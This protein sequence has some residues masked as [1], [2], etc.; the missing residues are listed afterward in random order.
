MSIESKFHIDT[1]VIFHENFQSEFNTRKLGGVPSGVNYENGIGNFNSIRNS[2][3][4]YDPIK[5]GAETNNNAKEGTTIRIKITFFEYQGYSKP[6]EVNNT[7][8]IG[9]YS[10]GIFGLI[11]S[12]HISYY[13]N[14]AYFTTP[15]EIELGKEYELV[16]TYIQI[17]YTR[18]HKM[19]VNGIDCG[20]PSSVAAWSPQYFYAIGGKYINYNY[21]YSID[22]VTIWRRTLSAKEVYLL[23]SKKLYLPP[24]IDFKG[25][26]NFY[27]DAKAY[28][29]LGNHSEYKIQNWEF[30]CYYKTKISSIQDLLGVYSG[31]NPYQGFI[32]RIQNATQIIF[33]TYNNDTGN[34]SIN[35]TGVNLFELTKIS[36]KIFNLKK[37]L[38][39]ND[40]LLQESPTGAIITYP[41]INW[42]MAAL[43]YDDSNTN[44]LNGNIFIPKF[45][46]LNSSGNRIKELISFDFKQTSGTT[47]PNIAIDAPVS[48]DG[49]V[50]PN[51]QTTDIWWQKLGKIKRVFSM[52]TIRDGFIRDLEGNTITN[53][54][55][56]LK[57]INGYKI[58]Y[59]NGTELTCPKF[60]DNFYNSTISLWFL[61][62]ANT[63]LNARI[64]YQTTNFR[65]YIAKGDRYQLKYY[66]NYRSTDNNSL[67][68]SKFHHLLITITNDT[69]PIFDYYINGEYDAA[70]SSLNIDYTV[71]NDLFHIGYSSFI[72]YIPILE[73]FD[74]IPLDPEE[75]ATQ[76]YNY[77]KT[78]LKII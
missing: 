67:I 60:K 63:P 8:S 29:D 61:I 5:T 52:N 45:Y 53:N 3:I 24:K 34:G 54:G 12:T 58:P 38:W 30:E 40:K 50:I 32:C 39:I 25:I 6:I 48:S 7:S 37:Q 74:G 13:N 71:L 16:Y 17:S 55:V 44:R 23:Y 78:I 1:D 68:K 42:Y 47:V 10:S 76:Q 70:G 15:F 51:G 9:N 49:T 43:N 41:D 65:F 66:G 69:I 2:V 73:I 35:Y 31:T 21:N 18:Y 57:N 19:Y 64:F 36:F 56:I 28:I 77:D 26:D 59:F 11:D 46:E 4:L 75:F 27:S 20:N 72:G 22:V 14:V 33:F 62:N